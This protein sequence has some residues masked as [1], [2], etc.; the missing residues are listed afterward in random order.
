LQIGKTIRI[1]YLIFEQFGVSFNGE[2]G[3]KQ[4]LTQ[5]VKPGTGL[6]RLLLI[7]A[8]TQP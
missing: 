7:L 3:G 2:N 4:I 8:Q 1:F 6:P 5:Q